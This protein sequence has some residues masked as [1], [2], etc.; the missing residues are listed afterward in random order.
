MGR[1]NKGQ[2]GKTEGQSGTTEKG[3]ADGGSGVK[4]PS[5]RK[6]KRS[7]LW[8][9]GDGRHVGWR[10][11]RQV[12][13]RPIQVIQRGHNPLGVCARQEGDRFVSLIGKKISNFIM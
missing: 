10:N 6:D 12:L 4:E 1:Q 3:R 5:T 13:N 7:S 11:C 2:L 9:K 8:P